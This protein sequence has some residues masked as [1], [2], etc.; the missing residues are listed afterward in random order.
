MPPDTDRPQAV[1]SCLSLHLAAPI[2]KH[3][4][5][6]AKNTIRD[7]LLVARVLFD[8]VAWAI[9]RVIGIENRFEV[10]ARVG[11]E[12]LKMAQLMEQ[13]SRDAQ[14]VLHG[15]LAHRRHLRFLTFNATEV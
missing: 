8:V 14:H 13:Q 10:R 5:L 15:R 7:Q 4:F 9:A 11:L 1:Q 3:A 6:T 12:S 2:M